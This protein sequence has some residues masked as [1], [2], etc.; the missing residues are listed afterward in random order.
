MNLVNPVSSGKYCGTC[1]STAPA[2]DPAVMSFTVLF[3]GSTFVA[4]AAVGTTCFAS[5][6]CTYLDSKCAARVLRLDDVVM[7]VSLLMVHTI[8]FE[9]A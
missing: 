7:E 3:F 5:A 1:V 8:L 4:T 2:A 6:D 9:T